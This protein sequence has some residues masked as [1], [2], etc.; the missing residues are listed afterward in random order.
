MCDGMAVCVQTS[1]RTRFNIYVRFIYIHPARCIMDTIHIYKY[2]ITYRYNMMYTNLIY[3]ERF[4][5]HIIIYSLIYYTAVKNRSKDIACCTI[6][7]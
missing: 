6:A 2:Y 1:F 5:I 3:C 4:I 7:V